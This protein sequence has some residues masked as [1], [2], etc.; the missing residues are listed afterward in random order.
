[1]KFSKDEEIS[2]NK[3]DIY[4]WDFLLMII[5]FFY[6]KSC[7]LEMN[8]RLDLVCVLKDLKSDCNRLLGYF[9]IERMFD[10]DFDIFW[11]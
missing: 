3:G 4:E 8:K 2:F 11:F 5:V 1:M 7:V 9:F 6:F 10:V